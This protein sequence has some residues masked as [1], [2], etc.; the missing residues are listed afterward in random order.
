MNT[1]T[2]VVPCY[3]EAQRLDFER[4][5]WFAASQ[6]VRFLMV[7]DGSRDETLDRLQSLAKADRQHFSVLNL[8]SNRGKAEAVR[9]GV[10]EASRQGAEAI[11][12]WDADLATP[13]ESIPEFVAV[14]GRRPDIEVVIGSRMPLLGRTIRRR[15]LRKLVGRNFARVAS[16]LLK[17]PVWDTQCGAKLFR[18]S[19]DVI[20]AFSQPF[21][22]RWLFDVELM[23]RWIHLRRDKSPSSRSPLMDMLFELPLDRWEDVAG[24]KLK[25]SDFLKALGE[26]RSIWWHY[27]RPGA[28]VFTAVAEAYKT[29]KPIPPQRRAA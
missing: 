26:L 28:P 14:L 7:N 13:L 6:D 17:T 3:N 15:P 4:Y 29:V 20:A 19:P 23:A 16:W 5:R 2:I 1:V 25:R 10:L 22:S 9:L 21:R 24:S 12:Y 27:L 18:A 8:E 11:G